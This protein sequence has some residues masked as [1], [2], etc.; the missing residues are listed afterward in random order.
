MG[1]M[2]EPKRREQRRTHLDASVLPVERTFL[3]RANALMET[4]RDIKALPAAKRDDLMHDVFVLMSNE[5]LLAA[6]ELH[7]H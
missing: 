4:A 7:W 1:S 3:A 5:W 2:S 6:E